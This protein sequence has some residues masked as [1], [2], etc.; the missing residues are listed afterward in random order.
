VRWL[1]VQFA[2]LILAACS[3][4]PPDAS[5]GTQW[6]EQGVRFTTSAGWAVR[7]GGEDLPGATALAFISN[8]PIQDCS[9]D[10]DRA[11]CPPPIA[12][13]EAGGVL[14]AWYET[15]CV[16]AGCDLPAGNQLLVGGRVAVRY[17]GPGMCDPL[18]ASDEEVVAVA[19]SPQRVDLIVTCSRDANVAARAAIA[20]L[21]DS[22]QW[23]T[24]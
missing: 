6:D 9:G 10:V 22:I 20:A 12:K 4:P 19:V 5:A 23:R 14:I 24:P 11:S 16:A 8:Q 1:L 7:T 13:L 2:L 21:F 18:L 15:H 17:A 3:S